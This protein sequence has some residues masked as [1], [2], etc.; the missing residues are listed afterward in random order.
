MGPAK[1]LFLY[2]TGD[3]GAYFFEK[4]T[5]YSLCHLD[6]VFMGS[7]DSEL[8]KELYNLMYRHDDGED[9]LQ[10]KKLDSPTKDWDHFVH[11]G[12]LW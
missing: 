3:G 2:V 5:D 4:I 9:L 8:E 12:D 6:G 10:I 7:K 11:V 1:T